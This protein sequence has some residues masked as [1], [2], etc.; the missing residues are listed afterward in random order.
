MFC[1]NPV[2]LPKTDKITIKYSI[3]T[4]LAPPLSSSSSSRAGTWGV[5]GPKMSELRSMSDFSG[6]TDLSVGSIFR[7]GLK[8]YFSRSLEK[9]NIVGVATISRKT[10]CLNVHF[11]FFT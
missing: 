1:H 6:E 5:A 8:N 10:F 7:L 3:V 11:L 9:Y 4:C 2:F